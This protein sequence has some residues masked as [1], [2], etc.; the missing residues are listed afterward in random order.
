MSLRIRYA[1]IGFTLGFAMVGHGDP[2][3]ATTIPLLVM[4]AALTPIIMVMR[5]PAAMSNA[6]IVAVTALL[7]VTMALA[8]LASLALVHDHARTTAG[9]GLIRAALFVV[10]V[11]VF[12]VRARRRSAH[13]GASTSATMP[14]PDK[15]RLIATKLTLVA[16]VFGLDWLVSRWLPHA[17]ILVAVALAVAGIAGGP[18]LHALVFSPHRRFPD[19][20]AVRR[21]QPR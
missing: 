1:V 18:A 17:G 21:T 14:M 5:R 9:L 15:G 16:I 19:T 6:R 7:A 11:P 12:I 13:T 8:T 10:V 4:F 3:S 2:F 20:E